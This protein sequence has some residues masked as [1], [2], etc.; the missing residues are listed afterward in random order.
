MSKL[1]K[2][3]SDFLKGEKFDRTLADLTEIK[4][5]RNDQYQEW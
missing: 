1:I 5:S 2:Q 3:K 4:K